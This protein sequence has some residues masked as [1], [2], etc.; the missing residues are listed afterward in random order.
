MFERVIGGKR[1]IFREKLAAKGCWNL[2]AKI[3]A[4]AGE[5]AQGDFTNA[6]PILTRA[7]ESWEFEGDPGDEAAY[8]A[9]DQI[10]EMPSLVGALGEY[11]AQKT[12][13]LVGKNL[14]GPSTPE[15]AST[16]LSPGNT[17]G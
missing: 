4:F 15:S 14:P 9:L 5:A 17:G 13:R 2:L 10:E 7:I 16:S 8:D 6:L 1:V 3:N 12:E 11:I